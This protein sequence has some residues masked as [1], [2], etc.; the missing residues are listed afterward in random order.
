MTL[1]VA[2][3]DDAVE[4]P[5]RGLLGVYGRAARRLASLMPKGLY[6]RA[7]IIIITPIVLLQAVV[8]FIFMERHWNTVTRRLSAAVV[9]DVAAIVDIVAT[10][11]QD[12]SYTEIERIARQRLALNMSILPPEPLP[13]PTAKPFFNLLD[14]ALGEEITRQ[15]AKP[16][17]IDTVGRSNIVEIRIQLDGKVLRVFAPRNSA[18]ASNSEIFIFYMVGTSVVLLGIAILFL[19]NQIRPILRLASAA[20]SFG[21]GRPVIDFRPRGAREV[22]RAGEAF[23]DMKD[24]I[25][26][27]IEQRTAMLAGVSHDLRTILTRFRLQLAL[28]GDSPDA[29]ALERDVDDMQRMLEG[30]LAFARGDSGERADPV[31]VAMLLD[32]IAR[33][34]RTAGHDITVRFAGDPQVRLRP[35]AYQR[36]IT[37]LVINACRHGTKTEVAATHQDGWL[38]VNVDDDGP[39]IPPEEHEAVFRPFYRLDEARNIDDS[40]TGL[41]LS[42]A[43]D[44][45]RSHGGEIR[46]ERSPLGGLRASVRIPA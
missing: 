23:V 5:K 20:E 18:Y 11:P 30:Y 34:A 19:R 33:Q 3:P 44:I 21:K 15:I 45:A 38:T 14:R 13:P 8:G 35:Q 10:Y 9:R 43:L 7:L 41:G 27:Q 28:L 46:L 36:C 24:R 22:R 26:R 39:G 29:L 6:A 37:N 12:T 31:D 17:W 40:G 1:T 2:E 16:F 32:E 4:T 42:I 25:E